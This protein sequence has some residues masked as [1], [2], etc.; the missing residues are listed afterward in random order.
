ME[1]GVEFRMI[2]TVDGE[3]DM[4]AA[5]QMLSENVKLLA[6][7][8]VSNVTGTVVD[9]ET[10]IAWQKNMISRCILMRHRPCATE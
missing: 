8:A 9:I 1:C 7:T 5:H 4:E 10:L 6:V 3:L 2:P